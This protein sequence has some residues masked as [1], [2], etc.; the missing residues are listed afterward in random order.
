M[1]S[2]VSTKPALTAR[3]IFNDHSFFVETFRALGYAPYGGADVGE[4]VSTA[5][6][7]PDS[8]E[9][10]SYN[11]QWRALARRIHA[12]ADRSATECHLVSARESDSRASKYYRLCE[13]S[14][15]VDSANPGRGSACS[16][17]GN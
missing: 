11:I 6:R 16:T 10:A 5:G 1:T 12:G 7:F 4:I 2:T 14:M 13:F 8:D 9:T 3:A 17:E 15:R